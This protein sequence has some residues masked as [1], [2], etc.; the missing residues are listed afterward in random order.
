MEKYSY[1]IGPEI[2]ILLWKRFVSKATR[3]YFRLYEVQFLS[4]KGRK[5]IAKL[6][7]FIKMSEGQMKL[8]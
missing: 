6:H 4:S 5:E 8:P 2:T 1:L 3:H 7:L